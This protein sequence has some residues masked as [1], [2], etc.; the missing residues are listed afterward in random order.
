MPQVRLNDSIRLKE[1]QFESVSSVNVEVELL[2]GKLAEAEASRARL[3][4]DIAEAK[5]D[6][7]LR[8]KTVA[9]RQKELDRDKVAAELSVL[10]RQADSRAQ[11]SIKRNELQS[12]M[13]Q[14]AASSVQSTTLDILLIRKRCKPRGQVQGFGRQ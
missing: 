11:L 13:G 7:S 10:N 12:K 3:E 2:E 8:D 4:E 14:V 6:E 9:I 1:S 5:Y